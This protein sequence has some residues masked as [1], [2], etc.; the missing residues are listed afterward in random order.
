[1]S[2]KI[3][4]EIKYSYENYIHFCMYKLRVE[5]IYKGELI[6]GEGEKGC[7]E[8]VFNVGAPT[9]DFI[10]MKLYSIERCNFEELENLYKDIVSRV[11]L[12]KLLEE[13]NDYIDYLKKEV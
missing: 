11:R 7:G 4:K 6:I 3:K 9:G 10:P 5:L 1:M 8:I 12:L 2:V 13:L